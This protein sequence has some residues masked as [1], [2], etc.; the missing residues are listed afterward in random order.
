MVLKKDLSALADSTQSSVSSQK[1]LKCSV[2]VNPH[3]CAIITANLHFA[4]AVMNKDKIDFIGICLYSYA[5]LCP[6][7][8]QRGVGTV[9]PGLF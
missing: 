6:W 8:G 1:T 2:F 5:A 3:F 4:C 9:C 7:N